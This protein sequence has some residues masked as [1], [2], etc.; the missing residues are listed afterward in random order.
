MESLFCLPPLRRGFGVIM[1]KVFIDEMT[2]AEFKEMLPQVGVAVVPVG[3]TEQHGPHLPMGTDM[4]SVLYVARRAAERLHPRVV[5]TP[6]PVM[7]GISAQH[8]GYPGT[9]TLSPET[10]MNAVFE[11]CKS[12]RRHGIKSVII[13]N[14]HGGNAPANLLVG[15]RIRD[16]LAM[17]VAALSYWD[18]LPQRVVDEMSEEKRGAPTGHGGI[19]G[20]AGEF[21]TS[22][23]MVI[24]PNLIR[25]DLIPKYTGTVPEYLEYMILNIE[26]KRRDGVNLDPSLAALEKGKILLNVII[27]ELEKYFKS[28]MEAR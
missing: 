24:H 3:S 9:L 10:F 23:A 4:A 16:E 20:H 14:G 19:P 27:D 22:M 15:Q 1:V 18:L 8:M 25:T 12:L 11:V 17:K 5:V 7:V 28:F 26:E 2:R 21:E 6:P 13:L